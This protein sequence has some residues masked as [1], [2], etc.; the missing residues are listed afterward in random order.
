MVASPETVLLET[1]LARY[2]GTAVSFGVGVAIGAVSDP[3]TRGAIN[4]LWLETGS[5]PVDPEL[6]ARIVAQ[7][8][9]SADWGSTEANHHGISAEKFPYIYEATYTAPTFDQ[10]LRMWRR[11]TVTDAQVAHALDKH[12]LEDEWYDALREL[13][14]ERLTIEEIA[15][16]IQRGILPDLGLLPVGP[17]QGQ[18]NV[19]AWTQANIDVAAELASQGYDLERLRARVGI[20]GLPASNEQAARGF[21]RGI[22]TRD[23]FD[24]AIAEG[25]TRNE[26]GDFILEQSRQILTAHNYQEAAL[27]GVLTNADANAKSA[28]HGM[29]DADATLLFE[30]I[31]RP[32]NVR[33]ITTGLARGGTYGGTYADVPEPYQDAIRRSN[34]RPEYAVLAHANRYSLPSAFVLRALLQ[35]GVLTA[36]QGEQYFLDIGWPPE[37]AKQ[38]ADFYGAATVAKADPH[39]TKAETQLWSALHK[40]YVDDRATTAL[41]TAT[42][43]KLGVADTAH[44]QVLDLWD[45]ERA[46]VRAGL[47]ATE[48]RKAVGQPGKDHAWA[49][50]R[51]AELGYTADDA[52]AF[53]AE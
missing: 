25:N 52:T 6:A 43:T 27:R 51:L 37:L 24:R 50:E 49:M 39:V 40:A 44:A 21:F 26:W 3:L 16:M 1:I 7:R 34:I 35:A 28:Q 48:I 15:T 45:A 5:M 4:D 20:I 42:L 30:I 19:I 23:D 13:K 53:L 17:P 2:G 10:L 38:V 18:G 14:G 41:A 36:A 9:A 46:I 11:S 22:G 29:S 31:G 12:M 8:I 47:S 33:G 32:L